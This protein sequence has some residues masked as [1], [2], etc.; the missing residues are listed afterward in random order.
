MPGEM[1]SKLK[2]I[3]AAAAAITVIIAAYIYFRSENDESDKAIHV[4]GNI[5][6]TEVRLSFQVS[7]RI[8]ELLVDE[9][10]AVSKGQTVA[11]LD[12]E[13][14]KR[15]KENAQAAL[16]QAQA[17][18]KWL[19]DEF[20]RAEDLFKSGADTAQ[21]R[22]SVKNKFEMAE[23]E[24]KVRAA[25][26]E[27]AKINLGYADLNSPVDSY[28]LVKSAEAGE[29]V[30]PGSTVFTVADLNDIW[31]TAYIIETDLGKVKLNQPAILKTDTFPDKEYKGRVSFIS[32]QAEFTPKQIQ[33]PEERVKLVYRI[34]ITVE[35]P[36]HELKP[37][38]PA[39]GYI[40]V[41]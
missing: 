10:Y 14:L 2:V 33:T 22:D 20:K 13:Q 6:A 9:G 38:M 19:S 36:N 5:E 37:G 17:N 23:A 16:E 41:E 12:K 34:K 32:Q 11:R 28:V 39:D 3:L 7:G 30:Q 21:Q 40:M 15:E 29:V 25:S 31:L 27:I 18:Y 35:N 24:L 8:S 26:L 4:S 1:K